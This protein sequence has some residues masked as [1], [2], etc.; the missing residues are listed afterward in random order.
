MNLYLGLISCFSILG[1]IQEGHAQSFKT[2]VTDIAVKLQEYIY[3]DIREYKLDPYTIAD[4]SGYFE[5]PGLPSKVELKLTNG[6]SYNTSKLA[7]ASDFFVHPE[8]N[9]F[10]GEGTLFLSDMKLEYDYR[11]KSREFEDQGI[12]TYSL[13][14]AVIHSTTYYNIITQ[15]RVSLKLKKY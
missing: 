3:N 2:D 4:Q 12:L 10:V 14:N 15:A 8:G 6:V 11:A 13:K 5:G 1:K 9:E 7:V